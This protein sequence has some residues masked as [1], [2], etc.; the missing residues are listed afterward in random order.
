MKERVYMKNSGAEENDLAS[1][2][3][4]NKGNSLLILEFHRI[5]LT[6]GS[7]WNPALR[8]GQT[9]AARED[10]PLIR[11][12]VVQFRA[13]QNSKMSMGKTYVPTAFKNTLWMNFAIN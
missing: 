8:Q 1:K 2:A 6:E 4:L 12:L 9:A 5:W 7:R 11:R 3:K 13:P 10:H